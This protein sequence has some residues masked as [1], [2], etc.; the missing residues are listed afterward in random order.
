MDASTNGEWDEQ[1]RWVLWLAVLVA[2][3]A[4]LPSIGTLGA[5]LISDDG[6]ALGYVHA[7]GAFADWFKPE[8]DLHTFRFWRPLVTV[9]LGLQ[10]AVFGAAPVPLR[11]LNLAGHVATALLVMQL[12]RQLGARLVGATLI[13]CLVALFP[14]QGGTVTWI[15]GRVDSQCV[16]LALG[17]IVAA[18]AGRSAWAG[19]LFFLA[20]ATKEIALAVPFATAALALAR[21]RGFAQMRRPLVVMALVLAGTILWRRVA[22]GTWVGGYPGG[23]ASSLPDGL[24]GAA[25]MA[26]LG[27][28]W[29]PMRWLLGGVALALG[30]AMVTGSRLV[31]RARLQLLG[32]VLLASAFA[33]APLLRSLIPGPIGPEHERVLMLADALLCVAFAVLFTRQASRTTAVLGGVLVLGLLGQRGAAAWQ[34]THD[35]ARAGNSAE[36]LVSYIHDTLTADDA[37]VQP[38]ALPVLRAAPPRLENGAY[39]LQWGFADRF[40]APFPETPRPVWP[41]RPLFDGK[42]VQ[43]NSVTRPELNLRWPFGRAPSMVPPLLVTDL[44]GQRFGDVPISA[45]LLTEPGPTFQFTGSFP[46][47]RFEVLCFTELGYGVGLFGGPKQRGAMEAVAPDEVVP[48]PFG[49]HA[50]LRELLML[51]PGG[52]GTGGP[53]L[54]EVIAL[55]ADFGATEAYLEFRAVDDARGKLDRPVGASKWIHLVWGPELRDA[56]LPFDGFQ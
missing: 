29:G 9:S 27:S 11:L 10:E 54:Y 51:E 38:S 49:G 36:G 34:D 22:I 13:G 56:V 25:V 7:H 6:A 21:G 41:W 43:R 30:V 45:S 47:A 1:R 23:L 55:A 48:L 20:L 40:R 16:P 33:L 44:A 50:S 35:W 2:L 52:T 42:D 46:G 31:I 24:G 14:Y 39:V 17:A 53:Q 28:I 3:V 8:Y 18:L 32:G 12:A 5:G 15:V 26:A 4:V 37:H 19:L